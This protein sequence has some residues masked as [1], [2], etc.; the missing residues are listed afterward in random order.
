[1]D[2]F[3][4]IWKPIILTLVCIIIHVRSLFYM[5]TWHA[6]RVSFENIFAISYDAICEIQGLG[7]LVYRGIPKTFR[8]SVYLAKFWQ[9]DSASASNEI[10]LCKTP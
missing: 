5:K 8:N 2:V 6:Q 3:L 1:M 4:K 9:F 10:S 7:Q